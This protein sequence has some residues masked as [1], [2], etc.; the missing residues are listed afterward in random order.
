MQGRCHNAVPRRQISGIPHAGL[1][2]P[3]RRS[4]ANRPRFVEI[5]RDTMLELAEQ[6]R[7]EMAVAKLEP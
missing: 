6:G 5:L 2:T 1:S 7:L 3:R 4:A